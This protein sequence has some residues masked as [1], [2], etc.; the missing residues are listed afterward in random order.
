MI[1]ESGRAAMKTVATRRQTLLGG[2]AATTALGAG[3]ASAAPRLPSS[4]VTL[5]VADIGGQLQLVQAAFEEYRRTHP[6]MVSR[7]TYT[8]EPAP[9][10]PGK[11]RAQQDAGR[12]DID[13][14]L[15]GTD[16]MSAGIDQKLWVPIAADYAD[17][18]PNLQDIYLPAAW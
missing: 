10:L 16:S 9:E 17:S 11:L 8:K 2:I 3:R 5:N 12:V 14:V 18:L 6:K 13:L 4:P 7:L 15:T 1:G